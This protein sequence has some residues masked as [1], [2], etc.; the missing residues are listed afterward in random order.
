MISFHPASRVSVRQTAV[1]VRT[2][3][4]SHEDVKVEYSPSLQ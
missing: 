2:G 3:L 4:L 1:S